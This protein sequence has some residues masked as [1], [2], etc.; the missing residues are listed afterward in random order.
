MDQ[1]A[2]LKTIRQFKKSLESNTE[3]NAEM[4]RSPGELS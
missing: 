4:E 1:D 2:V 3:D